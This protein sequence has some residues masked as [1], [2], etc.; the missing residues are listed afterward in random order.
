MER[1]QLRLSGNIMNVTPW[2]DG[3]QFHAWKLYEIPLTD[4]DLAWLPTHITDPELFVCGGESE[5]AARRYREQGNVAGMFFFDLEQLIAMDLETAY[6]PD[7]IGL[8]TAPWR[9]HPSGSLVYSFYRGISAQ[10]PY[11]TVAVSEPVLAGERHETAPDGGCVCGRS[12]DEHRVV[13]GQDL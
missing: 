1:S 12:D 5:L 8:L 6:G 9:G 3:Y 10:S 7:I 4:P 13:L 2:I 11:I